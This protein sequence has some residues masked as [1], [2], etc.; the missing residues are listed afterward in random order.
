MNRMYVDSVDLDGLVETAI[1]GMLE[2]LGPALGVHPFRRPA[3]S[4]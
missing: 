1:R 2:E 3:A 4:R